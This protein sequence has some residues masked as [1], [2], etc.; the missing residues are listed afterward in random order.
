MSEK[1]LDLGQLFGYVTQTLNQN[2]DELNAADTHNHDHGDHVVEVFEVV[3]QVAK[4]NPDLEAAEIL[5][6]ASQLLKQKQTG[7]AQ[8]YAQNLSQGAQKLQGKSLTQETLPLLIDA[9]LGTSSAK[10]EAPQQS[11]SQGGDLLGGLMG[12]LMGG[13]Q[14]P[15]E[16]QPS[17]PQGGGDLLGGLMG[18]LLGGGQ[19]PQEAQPSQPQGGGDLL[20]GLMGALMGGGQQTNSGG[21]SDGLDMGDLLRAG[22]AFMQ[23][24]QSGQGTLEAA[25]SALAAASGV[26][27]SAPHRAESSK[28]VMQ[29]LLQAA[30]MMGK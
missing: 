17:Q 15:Q 4:E 5:E 9:L 21:L 28:L 2:R 16:T 22:G 12:A 26:G 23:A 29:A 1:K 8:V 20:G 30:Q 13:G 10:A 6:R 18:A 19:A 25:L 11:Q 14:A 27:Q 24:S 3:T 7:T